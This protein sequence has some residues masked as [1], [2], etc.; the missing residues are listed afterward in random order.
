MQNSIYTVNGN[1]ELDARIEKCL[2]NATNA[3]VQTPHGKAISAI[4]LGGGYGR[5]EGGVFVAADGQLQM[6]NDLDLFVITDRLSRRH[7][8]QLDAEL[9]AVSVDFFT[10]FEV[11]VDF[12]PAHNISALPKVANTIMWQELK[13]KHKVIYGPE[14]ILDALPYHELN[15]L[16]L[17]EGARLLLNRGTGLLLAK[18][19][20][21]SDSLSSEDVD[22]VTRNLWKTVLACGDAFLFSRRDYPLLCRERLAALEKYRQ[23]PPVADFFELYRQAVKF[24]FSPGAVSISV[25]RTLFPVIL[26][27]FEKAYI[28]FWQQIVA[29]PLKS[30]EELQHAIYNQQFTAKAQTHSSIFKNLVLNLL[31]V[32]PVNFDAKLIFR[33]PRTRLFIV[34][35]CLLFASK[36][37]MNYTRLVSGAAADHSIA[38]WSRRY[39]KL[40]NRF[41]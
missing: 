31:Y 11:D 19:K 20:L 41:N 24:K 22:F 40:W 26:E 30:T 28:D 17:D 9:H 12:G 36:A 23:I 16:P 29:L 4:I 32:N 33:H 15:D 18:A 10:G 21:A 38:E 13:R 14:N 5:G 37:N 35:P 7:R 6:Y 2:E 39:F 3:A 25:A 8:K 1:A 27:Q 34:L